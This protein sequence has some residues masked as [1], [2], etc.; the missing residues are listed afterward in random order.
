[1]NFET[2]RG[3][4]VVG[5]EPFLND[6]YPAFQYSSHV[7]LQVNKFSLKLYKTKLINLFIKTKV[8]F[9]TYVVFKLISYTF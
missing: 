3:K 9:R 7:N 8:S 1:M 2:V 5:Q 6:E 4:G